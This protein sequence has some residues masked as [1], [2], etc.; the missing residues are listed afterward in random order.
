MPGRIPER[1]A[2]LCK[3][4]IA[5]QPDVFQGG[6]IQPCQPLALPV[7]GQQGRKTG[8]A[9]GW[10][11]GEDTGERERGHFFTFRDTVCVFYQFC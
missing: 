10:E 5:G 6:V 3:R 8:P 7:Q 11:T 4:G 9:Q 2:G 1:A